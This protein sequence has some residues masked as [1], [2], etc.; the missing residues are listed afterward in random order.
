MKIGGLSHDVNRLPFHR[1][2]VKV[3]RQSDFGPV[4]LPRDREGF[5]KGV[6][7]VRFGMIH[8][9]NRNPQVPTTPLDHLRREAT[10]TNHLLACL[11][12]G[13]AHRDGT[14]DRTS[15]DHGLGSEMIGPAK[16]KLQKLTRFPVIDLRPNH[17]ERRRKKPISRIKQAPQQPGDDPPLL[18]NPPQ[19]SLPLL[20]DPV[21]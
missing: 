21:R 15:K 13:P 6:E 20:Q 3:R 9:F 1:K 11:Q 8:V 16:S 17:F 10:K 14:R 12:F 5:G 4:N 7:E 18:K 2:V 19:A